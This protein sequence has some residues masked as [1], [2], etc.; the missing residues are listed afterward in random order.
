MVHVLD[1]LDTGFEP[2]APHEAPRLLKDLEAQWWISGGWALDLVAGRVTREHLD[3]DIGIF[4]DDLPVVFE[5][6]EE[7]EL[8]SAGDGK[9]V[10]MEGPG[11]LP[12]NANSIWARRPGAEK[13]LF[14]LILND[15]NE[16]E[17]IYRRDDRIRLPRSE[18]TIEAAGLPCI[19]PEIQLLF[20]AKHMRDR[21]TADFDTHAPDLD[22]A[23]R[24]W[25]R[26]SLELTRPG[27]PWIDGLT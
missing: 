26:S 2:I 8:H 27:H 15:G 9:L 19:R 6:L 12:E 7:T 18:M 20:K 23:S 25:L 10:L 4:V 24:E 14:E 16:H 17:W 13:W 5:A 21:D 3:L 22:D 11:D 1:A